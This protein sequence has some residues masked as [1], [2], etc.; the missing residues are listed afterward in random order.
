MTAT[1]IVAPDKAK[2]APPDAI[3]WLEA[4]HEAVTSDW[5]ELS[6]RPCT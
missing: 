1:R 5:A 2:S 6:G 4:E 3:A